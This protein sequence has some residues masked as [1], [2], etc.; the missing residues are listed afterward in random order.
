DE[1]LAIDADTPAGDEEIAR[2]DEPRILLY[3]DHLHIRQGRGVDRLGK[4]GDEFMQP[5]DGLLRRFGR[6][7]MAGL[8]IKVSTHRGFI[9]VSRC[10]RGTRADGRGIAGTIRPPC[11][12]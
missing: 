7:S 8:L 3:A 10:P 12:P 4:T 9:N 1:S 5:H 2:P 6:P 11:A